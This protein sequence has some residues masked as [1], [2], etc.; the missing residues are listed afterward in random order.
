MK[1]YSGVVSSFRG[2]KLTDM[3]KDELIGVIQWMYED[4]ERR[5]DR[6]AADLHSIVNLRRAGQ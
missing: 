6:H 3:T 1:E 4:A 5:R 2:K